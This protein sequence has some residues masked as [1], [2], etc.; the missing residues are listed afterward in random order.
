MH[1]VLPLQVLAHLWQTPRHTKVTDLGSAIRR[2]QDICRFQVPM[3]YVGL[4]YKAEAAEYVVDQF[5]HVLFSKPHP[6]LQEQIDIRLHVFHHQAYLVDVHLHLKMAEVISFVQIV[7]DIDNVDQLWHE[8]SL[9]G[10]C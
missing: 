7:R 9:A 2:D 3:Y 6:V 5:Q 4:M 1:R 10:I 8:N